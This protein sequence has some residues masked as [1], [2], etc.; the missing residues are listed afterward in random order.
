MVIRPAIEALAEA[1]AEVVLTTRYQDPPEEVVTAQCIVK[2][3][4]GQKDRQQREIPV[5]N[6]APGSIARL[7]PLEEARIVN[8]QAD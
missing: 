8:E 3:F 6:C 2:K 7:G 1:P 5:H 4:A